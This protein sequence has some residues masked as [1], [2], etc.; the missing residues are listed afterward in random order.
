MTLETL[1][2]LLRITARISGALFIPGFAGASFAKLFPERRDAGWFGRNAQRFMLAFA[3][4][5]TVHLGII[6]YGAQMVPEFRKML[7]LPIIIGGGTGF[8]FVYIATAFALWRVTGHEPGKGAGR[9]ESFALY[10]VWTIFAVAN[11]SKLAQAATIYGVY[12]ILLV[13]ALAVRVAGNLK[14]EE[15]SAVAAGTTR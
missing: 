11:F 6:L 7:I 1:H 12:A 14:R 13:A 3:T 10:F 9:L 2:L 15:A 5:Q 8:V 4:S